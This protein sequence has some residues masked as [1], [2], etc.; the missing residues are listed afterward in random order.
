MEQYTVY[1]IRSTVNGFL[2][3]GLTTDIKNRVS[4]HNSGKNFYTKPYIPWE[5]VYFK[6]FSDRIEARK[7]EKYLKSGIGRD[8]LKKYLSE[9]RL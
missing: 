6:V 1:V 5:L 9:N 2:Y 7:Y 8:F 3:K 4:E